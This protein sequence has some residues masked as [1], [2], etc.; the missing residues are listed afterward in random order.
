MKLRKDI[1]DIQTEHLHSFIHELHWM[2]FSA[3]KVTCF[4]S[5]TNFNSTNKFLVNAMD[6]PMEMD[7]PNSS[8]N[9]Q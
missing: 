8:V 5:V 2:Y 3:Q 1:H 4:Q 9:K 6:I 7:T